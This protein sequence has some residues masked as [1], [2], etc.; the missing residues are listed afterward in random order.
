MNII[1]QH[2]IIYDTPP[3]CWQDGL[4]MGN[5]SL[6]AVCFS[7]EALTFL[8][9]KTDVID[10]GTKKVKRVIPPA[11]AAEMVANGATAQDFIDAEILENPPE[12]VGPKTCCVLQMDLGM[13]AG[14]GTRSAMPSVSSR[15]AL[16]DASVRIKMDKH[17]C[18]PRLNAF[19]DANS[20]TF[21]FRAE[22][23]SPIVSFTNRLYFSRPQDIGIGDANLWSENDRVFM[24]ME[25]PESGYYIV[26]LHIVS[27][28][29]MDYRELIKKNIRKKY[30]AP[31]TGKA[32]TTVRGNYGIIDV[33][34][35]F[36]L[37]LSVVTSIESDNPLE[38]VN[39]NLNIALDAGV[40]A[41]DTEHRKWW[42]KFWSKST[43][44]LGDQKLN[45]L[46]YRSL[47]ALGSSYRTAPM[48]GL[49][50][51]YYGPTPGPIQCTP[52]NGDLHHDQ[53]VQCPFYPVFALNHGELFDAYRETYHS[54]LP[55]ARRLARDVFKV[56]G[57]HFDMCFNAQGHSMFQ[58][59]GQYRYGFLG[60]Y[61]AIVHCMAWRY[62]QDIHE[63]RERIYP[64]LKEIL[65]FYQSIMQKG[66]DGRYRLWP[67]NAV[68]LEVMDCANPV[69]TICML[70]VCLKTAI[71][72]ADI[73]NVDK[74]L[75]YG[76]QEF[77]DNL[78]DYPLG[79]DNKGRTVIVDGEGIHPDH[80]IGQASG[81]YP[82]Y[83]CSEF[84]EFSDP[85][86]LKLYRQTFEGVLEKTNEIVYADNESYY[87]KC[88]WACF[89]RAMTAI[90][91][92]DTDVFWSHYLP[93][94]MKA[95]VKP[96]GLCSHDACIIVDPDVS[97]KHLETIPDEYLMDVDERM[98]K[99]EVWC[100][101]SGTSTPN[102]NAKRYAVPLIEASA[103][104]LTMITETLLQSHNGV[105]RVFPAWP[106]NKDASFENLVA[107][108]D[109]KVS[110]EIKSGRVT[111]VRMEKGA[112][113]RRSSVTLKLPW[114][115]T[116]EEHM[117]PK[118]G[119]III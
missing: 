5:G 71:E 87:Y 44:E 108:G 98:S 30:H 110:S 7:P 24:K 12:G 40:D 72:A 1:S 63:L 119:V 86:V 56:E 93:M 89:Y 28:E 20:N 53:N 10:A 96:N 76:W 94:F 75:R 3:S 84:D 11:E 90:R 92:G 18:H 35:N 32:K 21:V 14:A 104:F 59:V 17:L 19:V 6:G 74:E 37:F 54:F 83:P 80:H 107:E 99:F 105:I 57:A 95:Y 45:A 116:V 67:A 103:D 60:S 88:V 49:L 58:G 97:E 52:W 50:G 51:L 43:V 111:F 112:N 114:T 73:L 13:T 64:F 68:E 46:F 70:K 91:L 106:K 38:Q 61:V 4:V 69:Q 101:H 9:N 55:E 42:H 109:V 81:L 48:S 62:K 47:Y 78:P 15:L 2:D 102:V 29:T 113:C 16:H 115:E 82:V 77:L 100:G 25:I 26:G 79:V 8:I 41:I 117:F 66:T 65:T 36:D 85:E 39:D 27:R 31:E 34:G 22:N 33:Q 23:I 118:H